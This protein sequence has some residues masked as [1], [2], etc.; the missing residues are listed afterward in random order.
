[1]NK[2]ELIT[3]IGKLIE[4]GDRLRG[5]AYNIY[6]IHKHKVDIDPADYAELLS[7]LFN[8]LNLWKEVKRVQ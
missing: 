7:E 5:M 8:A 2:E 4:A 6:F 3:F 1:M